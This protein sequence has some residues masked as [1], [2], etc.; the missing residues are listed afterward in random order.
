VQTGIKTAPFPR[1]KAIKEA[2]AMGQIKKFNV[3][4]SHCFKH[5]GFSVLYDRKN[6]TKQWDKKLQLIILI[7]EI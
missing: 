4:V 3:T 6:S 1:K 7:K 2:K 5:K